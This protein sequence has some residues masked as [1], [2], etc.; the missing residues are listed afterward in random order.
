MQKD[1]P[2]VVVEQEFNRPVR[3]VWEAITEIDLMRQWYFENIPDFQAKVGFRTEFAVESGCRTFLHQ[4]QV[5]Q[6]EAPH[7]LVYS[8]RYPD[9]EG[10]AITIFEVSGYHQKSRLTVTMDIVKSFQKD[11]PEFERESCVGGW[12][13][14]ICERLKSFL[15]Q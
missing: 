1:Q 9:F 3:D 12:N 8:W 10:D 11:I 7:K 14:F 6:V 4:W 5:T 2:P 15:E 13:Y